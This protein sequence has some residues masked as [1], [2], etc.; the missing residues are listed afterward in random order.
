MCYRLWLRVCYTTPPVFFQFFELLFPVL[1]WFF[2]LFSGQKRTAKRALSRS[3]QQYLKVST[4]FVALPMAA[5]CCPFY[6]ME[7]QKVNGE[8]LVIFY[9]ICLETSFIFIQQFF[10]CLTLTTH[11]FL[12]LNV[13]IEHNKSTNILYIGFLWIYLK[14]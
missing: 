3:V 10:Y 14:I 6:R 11:Y 5:I 12:M 7:S 13:V 8:P 1:N 9:R 4:S 2:A